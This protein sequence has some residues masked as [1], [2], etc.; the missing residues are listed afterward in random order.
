MRRCKLDPG[1]ESSPV[2]TKFD[3]EKDI[4]VLS[5]QCFQLEPW[6]FVLE[7]CRHLRTGFKFTLLAM[8]MTSDVWM[9]GFEDDPRQGFY[10]GWQGG[11]GGAGNRHPQVIWRWFLINLP[12]THTHTH[13]HTQKTPKQ[14]PK[15]FVWT[16]PYYNE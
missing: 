13:T 2:F 11:W 1:F 4:T 16:L 8:G 7:A 10:F 15:S 3:C 12:H 6:F 14:H 5:T 9:Y